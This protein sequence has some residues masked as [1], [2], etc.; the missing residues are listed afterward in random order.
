[1]TVLINAL[2][3]C[4]QAAAMREEWKVVRENAYTGGQADLES[5]VD[6]T[7]DLQVCMVGNIPWQ[8]FLTG[9]SDM[10]LPSYEETCTDR[11]RLNVITI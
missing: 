7:A 2:C 9:V 1:M 10:C 3:P 11:D 6:N 8:V 5:D 4:E